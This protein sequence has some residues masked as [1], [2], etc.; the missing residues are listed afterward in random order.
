VYIAATG[1]NPGLGGSASIPAIAL[2]AALGNCSALTTST[3]ISI[4][5][6][7]TAAAAWALAPFAQSATSLGTTSTNLTGIDNAF[8][9]AAN[10]A[11]ITTGQSP[12]AHL[13]SNATVN[14]GKLYALAS[15]LASCVNSDGGSPCTALFSAARPP[16]GAIPADTFQAA[17]DIVSHPANNVATLFRLI[18]STPPFSSGLT[19]AP[20]DWTLAV[21][22]TG[23]GLNAPSGISI[24]A[25]G[26][27][28]VANYFS[29][30]SA[31]SPTGTPLFASGITGSGLNHSYGIALDS[32][33]N[34]WVVNQ[35]TS[36]NSGKGSVSVL[37]SSGQSIGG[38]SGFTAGGLNFPAAVAIDPNSTTW[39]VNDGDSTVTLLSSTGTPLSGA[40][41]YGSSHL[42]FPVAIALDAAHNGWV[43][44]QSGN[45]VSRISPDGTQITDFSCCNGP[46]GIAVDQN[47]NAWVT[48]YYG[49]SVSRITGAGAITT[50]TSSSLDHPQGI[51]IDGAGSV[52]IA[53]LFGAPL[54]QLAGSISSSPGSALSP[55]VGWGSDTDIVEP[56]SVAVDA[57]GNLWL[58]DFGDD[59]LTQFVGLA[60]PIKTPHLGPPQLP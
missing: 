57:S 53:N 5:E 38:A 48:N 59:S 46:S 52:W 4:N 54:T 51:A 35:D 20:P 32:G 11:E 8:L 25:S 30:I 58:S 41:G 23:G 17:L 56:Y 15:I 49:N 16:A 42:V 14:S 10:L 9:T 31:F 29:S 43:A 19:T 60:T 12:G 36:V 3:F 22:F 44:N 39:I 33:N 40:S 26:D 37:N 50:F 1:G 47:S 55:V 28:W 34:A 18:P 45:T 2:I 24:D 6:V 21:K 13:P 27:V 7:T